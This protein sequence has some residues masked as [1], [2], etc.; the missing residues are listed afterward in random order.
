MPSDPKEL[1][2]KHG[3]PG[4]NSQF[5]V[6][7][8][9]ASRRGAAGGPAA[10]A[11][12]AD[13]SSGVSA[14]EGDRTAGSAA[15][16]GLSLSHFAAAHRHQRGRKLPCSVL[17]RGART[18]ADAEDVRELNSG[19]CVSV[20]SALTC[21]CREH[22]RTAL[23][24][25]RRVAGRQRCGETARWP[26]IEVLRIRPEAAS[27][28]LESHGPSAA[29]RVRD[30]N[31]FAVSCHCGIEE[32]AHDTVRPPG[33]PTIRRDHGRVLFAVRELRRNLLAK[34]TPVKLR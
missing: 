31:I 11:R 18:H 20:A 28:G 10:R 16:I 1:L 2:N 6:G 8:M 22:I 23:A 33:P 32:A 30:D 3:L 21:N 27:R 24:Q 9:R 5:A 12:G 34:A 26:W 17:T 4:I 15:E 25:L 29:E 19:L 13:E 7:T 14:T